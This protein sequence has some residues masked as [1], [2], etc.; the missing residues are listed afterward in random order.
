MDINKFKD[1]PK[2]FSI[3]SYVPQT[4]LL[5]DVD[6][7]ITHGGINSTQEGLS[8]GVPLIVVPQQYDQFDNAKRVEELEAGIALD[9]NK[10]EITVDVLK[11]AVNKIN[12][13]R[14]KYKKGIERILQSY[15]EARDN[16]KSIYEKIFV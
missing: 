10:I 7:F 3:F 12:T 9:R 16:R 11:D 13:N 6:I 4:Q 1:A 14:E 15:K 8:F 2:N 5:P